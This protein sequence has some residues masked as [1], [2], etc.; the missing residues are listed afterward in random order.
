MVHWFYVPYDIMLLFYSCLACLINRLHASQLGLVQQDILC[1]PRSSEMES[2][3]K[4][5]Q[6]EGPIYYFQFAKQG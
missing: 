4:V 5:L 2:F 6:T 3:Y 1:L